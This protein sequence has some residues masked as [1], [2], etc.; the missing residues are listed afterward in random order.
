MSRIW[1][2]WL[3]QLTQVKFTVRHVIFKKRKP[4]CFNFKTSTFYVGC[5]SFNYLVAISYKLRGLIGTCPT[6]QQIQINLLTYQDLFS[7]LPFSRWVL[8]YIVVVRILSFIFHCYSSGLCVIHVD[9]I[10]ALLG[11]CTRK[12]FMTELLFYFFFLFSLSEYLLVIT[13]M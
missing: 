2:A 12:L 10:S 8:G 6:S 4:I 11:K 7:S 5:I 9:K 13:F 1:N 3:V